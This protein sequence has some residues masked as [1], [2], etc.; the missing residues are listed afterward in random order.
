MITLTQLRTFAALARQR[1]FTRAAEEL[2]VAQPSVSYQLREL[3]RQLNVRLV[4]V[5][6]RRVYLTDAGER[7]AARAAGL[8][9]E[10]ED[11]E[12]EMRDFGAGVI[13]RLRLGATRTV[14]GY[15]LPPALARFR[16]AHPNIDLRLTIDNTEAVE[17]M[18]LERA[19][20]LAVVEWTVA[21]P[22][23]VSRPLRRDSL[24]LVAS[25]NHPLA[26]IA[27]VRLADLR[28]QTFV[29]REPGSGT[30]ALME[31]ALAPIAAEI[32]AAMELDEPEGIVRAV[33]A[34][35]GLT[36]I[37]EVIVAHQLAAGTLRE[38]KVRGLSLGRDFSLVELR[39][40]TP[41]R[42]MHRFAA[43]LAESWSTG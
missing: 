26:Q 40:R 17:Q 31:Q 3:E 4:E 28:G 14:G 19:I 18:L 16:L 33:E 34:G 20:D 32:T 5:V 38:I 6:G 2:G 15:A 9:N 25:A 37:S 1:H 43:F 36:F 22:R 42:A 21:S 8:L 12:R 13:G 10:L 41:S 29:L 30:R 24:V 23:L 7:L 11:V 35:M 39:E 27:D